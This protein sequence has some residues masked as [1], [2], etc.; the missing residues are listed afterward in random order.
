MNLNIGCFQPGLCD[1]PFVFVTAF[2]I[3]ILYVPCAWKVCLLLANKTTWIQ[4]R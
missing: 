2:D 4:T 3:F 1:S